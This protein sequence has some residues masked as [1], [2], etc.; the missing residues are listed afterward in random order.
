LFQIFVD[1]FEAATAGF[2][3]A[4]CMTLFETLFWMKWGTQSVAEWQVNA[5]MVAVISRNR[6]NEK[7]RIRFAI[8]MHLVHGIVLGVIF[9]LILLYVPG[10]S[11]FLSVTG[12]AIIYSMLLW[13]ISPWATRRVYESRGNI[14][15]TSWGLTVSFGS[16]IIYGLVLG[17]LIAQI[18]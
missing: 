11:Q 14:R 7:S 13:I 6:V 8:A 15:M 1:I 16:H 2:L 4:V 18:V 12:L 5:V 10:L 9:L 17:V 3:S